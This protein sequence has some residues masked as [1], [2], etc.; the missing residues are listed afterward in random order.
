ML[1]ANIRSAKVR[2]R[3]HWTSEGSVFAGTITSQCHSVEIDTHVESDDD[4]A[5]IAAVIRNAQGGCYADAALTSAVPVHRVTSLNGSR[6][7]PEDYP[8]KVPRRN[9]SSSR[10]SPDGDE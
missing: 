4:V 10:D 5:L 2:V 6:L 1:Q 9:R 8:R 3:V 7:I